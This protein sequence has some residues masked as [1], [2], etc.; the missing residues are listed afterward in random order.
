MI[1]YRFPLVRAVQPTRLFFLP[2]LATQGRDP[3]H[4]QSLEVPRGP[5]AQI[6]RSTLTSFNG[7]AQNDNPSISLG[8]GTCKKADIR[9]DKHFSPC[10]TTWNGGGVKNGACA[11][12]AATE[13]RSPSTVRQHLHGSLV[14]GVQHICGSR[15]CRR[16]REH[17]NNLCHPK[18][19]SMFRHSRA[20][21]SPTLCES[22]VA[23]M[24]TNSPKCWNAA[25]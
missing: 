11:G 4:L 6:P 12:G 19:A 23:L 15:R 16:C 21:R 8:F 5:S 24:S 7:G 9:V 1:L 2:A 17:A 14:E 10:F 22:S 3:L 25:I 13:A 20:F 18:D